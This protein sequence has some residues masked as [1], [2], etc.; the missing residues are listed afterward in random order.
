MLAMLGLAAV[1]WLDHLLRNAG[2]PDLVQMTSDTIQPVLAVVIG[3][4]LGALV[5]SRRPGHPVGWLLLGVALSFIATAAAAQ[6]LV[7]GLLVRPGA[8]PGARYAALYQPTTAFVALVLIGF[9]LL[10][11]PSGFLPSPRWRWWARA[12]MAAPVFLLVIVTLAPEPFDP[13]YQALGGPFDFRG[14][15]GVLLVSH[16]IGLAVTFLGVLVAAGS[17]VVRFRRARG[18]EHQQLRWVA[19]GSAISMLAAVVVLIGVAM[20]MPAAVGWGVSVCL[21]VLPLAIG[22]AVLRYRLYDID[23]IINRALVYV[24]LT[25]VLAAVYVL[26]VVGL[27]GLVREA[28]GRENNSLVVAASTLAVAA[29]F[30]P[31]R[32]RVQGFIDRRFYRGRYDAVQTLETFSAR[33]RDEVDLD[34][35]TGDLLGV[36]GTTM[37]PRHVSLWLRDRTRSP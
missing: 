2:R 14:F 18:D 12:M 35:V 25:A 8:L 20:N 34:A 29:L 26:G 22:A 17:L 31:A 16:Q 7:Y 13:R 1:P 4:T 21:V 33:L 5:A 36:V 30:R 11:T 27:G 9:V 23:R 19:A 6:Y 10:L 24:A 15:S 3:A 28:T 32:G 37:Q